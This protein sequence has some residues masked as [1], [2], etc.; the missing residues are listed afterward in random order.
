ME[1]PP[2]T[3]PRPAIRSRHHLSYPYTIE[4]G[5]ETWC[6]P[7]CSESGEVAVYRRASDDGDWV[8]HKVIVADFPAIDP[9]LF[10]HDGHWWLFCTS[11]DTGAN[12]CLY[13]WHAED[14][15]GEW[16]PHPGNPLKV[17]I[18][19]ARPAGRPFLCN[20]A[21]IRPAQDCSRQYGGA[22]TFNR[23]LKL[24]CQE[25]AE[26]PAGKL[27]PDRDNYPAG[28]HTISSI[29]DLVIVD[30]ARWAFVA[31]EFRRA[32]RKKLGRGR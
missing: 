14:L 10:E 26:E 21:L 4:H 5:G 2:G 18:R 20:G 17:D 12:E 29:N 1:W 9:T 11:A 27:L 6:V 3:A 32:L 23:I 28:L 24:T 13:A 22:I 30:G 19:G 8:K 7:E 16:L 15:F 25:F 31:A